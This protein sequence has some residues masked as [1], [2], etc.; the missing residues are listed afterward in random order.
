M[1][2]IILSLFIMISRLEANVTVDPTM[3]GPIGQSTS[4]QMFSFYGATIDDLGLGL[5]ETGSDLQIDLS[6]GFPLQSMLTDN[7]SLSI[8]TNT[9]SREVFS[10]EDS[11]YKHVYPEADKAVLSRILYGEI[12]SYFDTDGSVTKLLGTCS[13][14]MCNDGQLEESKIRGLDFSEW[15]NPLRMGS[16]WSFSS[17]EVKV[18]G[19]ES[20]DSYFANSVDAEGSV[21]TSAGL[22]K[23][24]RVS[25]VGIENATFE[26]MDS[27]DSSELF[28]VPIGMR[29]EVLE[30][31][32]LSPNGYSVVEIRQEIISYD[33]EDSSQIWPPDKVTTIFV[34]TA[35]NEPLNSDFQAAVEYITW[36]NIKKGNY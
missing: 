9:F 15:P 24:L 36:G 32:W 7:G 14:G 18:P 22:F 4:G 27:I 21:I 20:F 16:E 25:R 28:P 6:Q 33:F 34:T 29:S 31:Y 10:P 19:F 8:S 17:G 12:W 11:P 23:A 1:K 26:R 13:I 35:S 5:L 30:H 2:F 3:I